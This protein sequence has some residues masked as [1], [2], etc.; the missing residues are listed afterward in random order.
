MAA[1]SI[2]KIVSVTGTVLNTAPGNALLITNAL[3]ENIL[4]PVNSVLSFT[5]ATNVGSYF[6]LTSDEYL[7]AVT[8]FKS[9]STSL[10]VPGSILFSRYVSTPVSAYMF[11]ANALP[12]NT[13]TAIKAI[14]SP[15]LTLTIDDAGLTLSLAQAD[16]T[17]AT[18]LTDIAT[19]IE[20]ALQTISGY[21]SST[22]T[23]IGN[24]QFCVT[25]PT[26]T[27]ADT[28]ISY[29]TGNLAALLGLSQATAP[30]LSQGTSGGNAAFNLDAI[31]NT[32]SN[33]FSLSYVTRLTGDA[34]SD[35]YAVTVDLTSWIAAQSSG[36][37]YIGLWWEGGTA[38]Y[39]LNSTNNLTYYLVD[40]GY[41]TTLNG[42]TTLN[43]P[44]QVDYNGLNS[45]NSVTDNEIGIY[46]AF[47]GGM[48]ASINYN[49]VNA[50]INF[51]GKQQTGLAV[52]VTN[53]V[54][55]EQLLLNAYN[56]YAQF[57]SRSA[58][59]NMSEN[60][61]IGGS[62]LWIDNIY[63][64]AWLFS[65]EQNQLAQLLQNV[66]RIP[67]NAQGISTVGAVLTNVVAAA[68]NAGVIEA[69][70]TFDATQI[71]AV[72]EIVGQDVSSL[73]TSNGYYLYFPPITANQRVNRTPLNVTLIYSNG[74]AINQINVGNVFVQ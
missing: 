19:V 60:G 49:N 5:N 1:V 32:N 41:G 55:Y 17:A 26:I 35:E 73:L 10:T 9:Y 20:A 54:Q 6:G 15:T 39:T 23:I 4:A 3:T 18:G 12:K 68:K 16:F 57:S 11:S 38:P 14:A 74:G 31:I 36:N 70:N 2:D 61:V 66:A 13:V 7:F 56:V 22:C 64:A 59:F 24:N 27:P 34:Q 53:T 69:G 52:N 58:S 30:K 40:A 44:V 65:T 29:A 47:V 46:A 33:W 72:T 8:Y 50:K 43:V 42:Q 45:F 21:S 71:Q 48:G 62:Y 63:D 67:Y 28:T 51:A 25:A 37:P